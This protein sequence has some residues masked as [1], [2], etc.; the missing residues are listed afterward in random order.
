MESSQWENLNHLFLSKRI[1]ALLF[2]NLYIYMIVCG[3][4]ERRRIC[5]G[6]LSFDCIYWLP[7]ALQIL[8]SSREGGGSCNHIFVTVSSQDLNFQHY[9][10]WP[11]FSSVRR[12]DLITH[13]V[14]VGGIVDHNHLNFLFITFKWIYW[15]I[16]CYFS[17]AW[18]HQ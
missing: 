13:S 10:S 3:L 1:F 4:F 5:E 14:D 6:F 9:M 12:W 18:Q 16:D 15:L 11:F 7:L 17:Y 2:F 8:L